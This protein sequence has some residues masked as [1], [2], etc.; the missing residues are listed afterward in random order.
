MYN[1]PPERVYYKFRNRLLVANKYGMRKPLWYL[2]EVFLLLNELTK[3]LL[4]EQRKYEKLKMAALGV[5]DYLNHR[6][7]K[8]RGLSGSPN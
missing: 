4:F 3:I 6:M 1:H 5:C 8:L 7:G 2:K